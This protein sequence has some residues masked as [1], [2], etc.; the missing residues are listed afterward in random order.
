LEARVERRTAELREANA[1]LQQE[2]VQR[3]QAE[4]A[5]RRSEAKYRDL[6]ENSNSIILQMDTEGNITFFNQ[7][8]QEFFGYTEEEILGRG[9]IGTIVP[10][11]QQGDM[12]MEAMV[13]NVLREPE[14]YR[15]SE[16]E[17]VRR[18]G[19]RVWVAWTNK[20]LYD[21]GGHLSEILSIGVDRTEQKQAEEMLAQREREQAIAAERNRLARDLHDAVTQTLFSASLIA[22]VLPRLWERNPEEGHRRLDELRELT[23]GALAEMRTLLLELRPTALVEAE[24]GDLLRQL[25]ESI[26]GRSRVPVELTVTGRCDLP[27]EV[28]V[29]FYRIAQE[30]LNNVAKH[31]AAEEATVRMACQPNEARLCV[32]DDGRGFDLDAVPPDSLGLGIMR[33]RAEGIDAAL[34]VESK[35]GT[36]TQVEVVWTPNDP[37]GVDG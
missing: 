33:E 29:A 34:R 37:G 19:E 17:N 6:V 11:E 27:A 5:L 2:I 24:L 12:D 23:R 1:R 13:R 4:Q 21:E 7:F 15:T 32:R 30:A 14:A 31:A 25:A 20:A 22:E 18:N 8:A 26:T 28:K 9:V 10:T 3:E 16:N 35:P 36:G